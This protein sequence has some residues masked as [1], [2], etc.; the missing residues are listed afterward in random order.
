MTQYLKLNEQNI[1]THFEAGSIL[2]GIWCIFDN[3][4]SFNIYTRHYIATHFS[5]HKHTRIKNSILMEVIKL[6][7]WNA[8]L[9]R[10]SITVFKNRILLHVMYLD[11]LMFKC[12]QSIIYV[13]FTIDANPYTGE[14]HHVIEAMW[15]LWNMTE[16]YITVIQ[17]YPLRLCNNIYT[18]L[19]WMNYWIN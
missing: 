3:N 10:Q 8:N 13:H 4:Q 5:L 18:S 1:C 7:I 9:S 11:G 17:I 14:P 15:L 12:S 2:V 19:I 16:K 6:E